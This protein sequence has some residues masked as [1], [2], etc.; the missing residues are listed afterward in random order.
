MTFTPK[1]KACCIVLICRKYDYENYLSTLL[2]QTVSGRAAAFVLRAFYIE[3]AQV[4]NSLFC[5]YDITKMLCLTVYFV[6]ILGINYVTFLL[7]I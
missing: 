2:L 3:L 5:K 7:L 6:F 1:N 4:D